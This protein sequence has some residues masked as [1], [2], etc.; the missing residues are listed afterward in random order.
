MPRRCGCRAARPGKTTQTS[1]AVVE[2][3]FWDLQLQI[4]VTAQLQTHSI[5]IST[6]VQCLSDWRYHLVISAIKKNEVQSQFKY[7]LYR[8][9]CNHKCMRTY[10]CKYKSKCKYL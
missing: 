3:R 6:V 10:Q 2:E 7:E 5:S 9:T 8:T 4:K 1:F